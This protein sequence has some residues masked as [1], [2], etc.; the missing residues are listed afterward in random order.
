MLQG[1][2]GGFLSRRFRAGPGCGTWREG[3]L[4][5]TGRNRIYSNVSRRRLFRQSSRQG[6]HAPLGRRVGKGAWAATVTR[7]DRGDVHDPRAVAEVW[8]RGLGGEK[9]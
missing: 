7:G 1:G 3:G 2:Q 6:H 5:D 9:D 8:K 4:D